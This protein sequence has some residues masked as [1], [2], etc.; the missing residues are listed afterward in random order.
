MNAFPVLVR[1]LT[2][3]V[4]ITLGLELQRYK[5]RIG[6]ILKFIALFVN[7]FIRKNEK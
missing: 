5:I 2:L 4:V 3:I 6:F 7:L 1:S